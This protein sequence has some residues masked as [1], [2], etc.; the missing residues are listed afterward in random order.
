MCVLV[1]THR[2]AAPTPA[3][4]PTTPSSETAGRSSRVMRNTKAT[5]KLTTWLRVTDDAKAPMA[6]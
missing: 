5:R 2:S 1:E 4:S 3:A 6:T